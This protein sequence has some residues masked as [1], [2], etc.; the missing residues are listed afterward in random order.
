MDTSEKINNT[1]KHIIVK[2]IDSKLSEVF[3]FQ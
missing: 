2:L 3:K 1:K